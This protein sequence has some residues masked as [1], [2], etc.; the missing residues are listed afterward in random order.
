MTLPAEVQVGRTDGWLPTTE[1][2]LPA[3]YGEPRFGGGSLFGRKNCRAGLANPQLTPFTAHPDVTDD[4]DS[5]SWLVSLR[6]GGAERYPSI[7]RL[8]A[9]LLGAARFE[10]ARRRGNP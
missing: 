3:C 5:E 2:G 9:S 7:A 6:A 1:S 8:H 10:V 4:R